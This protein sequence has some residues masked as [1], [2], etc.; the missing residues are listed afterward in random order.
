MR[1]TIYFSN[2]VEEFNC[3]YIGNYVVRLP[4]MQIW[5]DDCILGQ[6]DYTYISRQRR[7]YRRVILWRLK[8]LAP[9]RTT[10]EHGM[11]CGA[12]SAVIIL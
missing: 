1:R 8:L 4:P 2:E 3:E 9:W 5:L 7:N 6:H 12:I 10:D 11:H